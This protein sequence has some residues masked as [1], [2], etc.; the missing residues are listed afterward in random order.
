[1]SVTDASFDSSVIV[2]TSPWLVR[3]SSDGMC[4]PFSSAI[5]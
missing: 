2:P 4:S 1:M 3:S 5:A